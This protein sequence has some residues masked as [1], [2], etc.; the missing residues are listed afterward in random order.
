MHNKII[1]YQAAVM[2]AL[3]DSSMSL[4]TAR[5]LLQS[6]KE[7]GV[8]CDYVHE[9]EK[10]NYSNLSAYWQLLLLLGT[11]LMSLPSSYWNLS[12]YWHLLLL[13]G[14]FLMSLLPALHD[15]LLGPKKAVIKMDSNMKWVCSFESILR[16]LVAEGISE[17][18]D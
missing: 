10:S 15:I 3:R 13:L 2:K 7:K 14:I 17:V 16:S 9:M 5:E 6:Q 1:I 8:K 11:F 4:A 18:S 12:A